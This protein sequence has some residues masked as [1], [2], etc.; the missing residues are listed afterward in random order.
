[1]VEENIA[2]EEDL[3]W[4]KR[5]RYMKRCKAVARRIWRKEKEREYITALQERHNMQHKSRSI[6]INIGN[7]VMIKGEDKKLIK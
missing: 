6:N 5:Q 1:M 3:G 4:R 7:T 2:E